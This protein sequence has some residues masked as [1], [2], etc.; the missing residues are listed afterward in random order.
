MPTL[1]EKL[2]AVTGVQ[3][4]YFPHPTDTDA[5]LPGTLHVFPC[6]VMVPRMGS[7]VYSAGGPNIMVHRLRVTLY[8]TQQVLNEAYATATPFIKLVRDKLAANLTLGGLVDHVLPDT[9]QA[10]FYE[11]PGGIRYGEPEHL[12]IVFY[13]EVKEHETVTVTA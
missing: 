7:Q 4:V 5:G 11:G 9:A 6:I 13:V 8:V 12:G 3:A 2:A 1:A 10:M